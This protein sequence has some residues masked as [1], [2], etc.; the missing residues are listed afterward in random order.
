[1][2]WLWVM[3]F[4]G[5]LLKAWMDVPPP[6]SSQSD[7]VTGGHRASVSGCAGGTFVSCMLRVSGVWLSSA[8]WICGMFVLKLRIFI[9]SSV[10]VIANVLGM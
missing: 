1:V 2:L 6:P 9:C 5:I 4:V 3:V 8:I 7:L 10:R